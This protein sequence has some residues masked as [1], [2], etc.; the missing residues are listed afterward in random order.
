VIARI[1]KIKVIMDNQGNPGS[2]IQAYN[3]M[4]NNNLIE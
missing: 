4:K 2:D 3:T 1:K